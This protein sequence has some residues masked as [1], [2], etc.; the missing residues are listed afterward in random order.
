M[1]SN[2]KNINMLLDHKFNPIGIIKLSVS[3]RVFFE[4]ICIL[5]YRFASFCKRFATI[6]MVPNSFNVAKGIKGLFISIICSYRENAVINS[7]FIS[8]KVS[9]HIFMNRDYCQ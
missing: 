9:D 6:L 3:S 7:F 1:L 4:D 2:Q 8:E 5:K